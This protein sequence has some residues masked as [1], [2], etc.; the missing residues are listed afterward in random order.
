[1]TLE[2]IVLVTKRTA[3]EGLIARHGTTS[4]VKFFLE[5]RGQHFD[6]YQQ[7][8]Q[9]YTAGINQVKSAV[10]SGMR[11]QEVNKE[12]LATFQ[13]G[14]K[15]VIVV[16]GDPGLFVNTAKYVGEQPVIMVNPDRERFDDVFTT[17]YPDGFA[18]KLQETVA[19]K[20][21]C[22]KLTLAQAVL[23]NGEELYALNDFLLDE[24]H[25][26][27]HDMKLNLQEKVSGNLLVE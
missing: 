16:V 3:L 10:P 14:D 8:H 11:F 17:C 24:E 27:Q 7:A 22:E 1:M 5:S 15:D 21:T 6:F 2:K 12:H 26:S 20:Y 25:I 19:G 18:R 4:Q 9:A 23:E 13:V